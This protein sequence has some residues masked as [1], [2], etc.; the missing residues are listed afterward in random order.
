M[1][2]IYI[3][4]SLIYVNNICCVNNNDYTKTANPSHRSNP[5]AKVS[6]IQLTGGKLYQRDHHQNNITIHLVNTSDIHPSAYH[7]LSHKKLWPNAS[8]Q[9]S[10]LATV[11]YLNSD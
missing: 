5:Y 6:L 2:Y 1:F 4:F 7:Y 3:S 9:I 8:H 11:V 10:H